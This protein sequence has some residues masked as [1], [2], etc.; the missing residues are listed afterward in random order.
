M[1]GQMSTDTFGIKNKQ[2]YIDLFR[3]NGFNFI[4]IPQKEK[5]AEARYKA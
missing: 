5:V 2:Y 3:R 4:P 1:E